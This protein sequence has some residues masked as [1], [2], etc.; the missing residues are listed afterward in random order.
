MQVAYKKNGIV[1]IL[2]LSPDIIEDKGV[3]WIL[4]KD[5]PVDVT[6]TKVSLSDFSDLLFRD[7]W[8][9]ENDNLTVNLNKAKEISHDMR[10]NKRAELLKPLDVEATVPSLAANAET[11]RQII[12]DDFAIIQTEI[13]NAESVDQLKVIIA[14]L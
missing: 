10:R 1:S 5:L 11:Q 8:D 6:C 4:K 14:Q 12:R 9:I 3:D 2:F 13:D 7:A